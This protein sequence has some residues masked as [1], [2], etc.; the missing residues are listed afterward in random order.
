MKNVQVGKPVYLWRPMHKHSIVVG[1]GRAFLLACNNSDDNEQMCRAKT[2]EETE[3]ELRNRELLVK[4]AC[5]G[6]DFFEAELINSM[7]RFST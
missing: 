4:L 5:E 7:F 1:S 6:N 3:Y 2:M